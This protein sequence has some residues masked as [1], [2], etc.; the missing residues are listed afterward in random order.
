VPIGGGPITVLA[1]G[2]PNPVGVAVDSTSLYW[3][4]GSAGSGSVVKLTPK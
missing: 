2:Q 1:S 3:T 4:E